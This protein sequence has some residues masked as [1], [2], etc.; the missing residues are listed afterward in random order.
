PPAEAPEPGRVAG[1]DPLV[2]CA[3]HVVVQA[4]QDDG[5]EVVGV[6]GA[7]AQRR[8]PHGNTERGPRLLR[9]LRADQLQDR[10]HVPCLV[11]AEARPF[12]VALA[13]AAVVEGDTAVAGGGEKGEA[14]QRLVAAL[15]QA[16][17]EDYG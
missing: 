8:G 11:E 13:V 10:R 15:A 9:P 1:A 17:E 3:G 6:G 12:T 5:V 16:V 2:E 14:F 4:L 7:E